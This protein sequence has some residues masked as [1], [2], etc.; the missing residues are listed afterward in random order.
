MFM[1]HIQK[2][3]GVK[4]GNVFSAA[5]NKLLTFITMKTNN[6]TIILLCIIFLLPCN[7]MQAQAKSKYK[8]IWSDEFN[9]TGRPDSSKWGYDIGGDGWGNQELEYYTNRLQNAKVKKGILKITLKK[10]TYN[11]SAYTSARLLSK[12]KFE[13]TYGKVEARAKLPVGKGT[14]PAIWMLGTN[15]DSVGWPHCGEIDIMEHIGRRQDTIYATF[16]YPGHSG[17]NAD[18]DTKPI[19]NAATQFHLYS[20][21]W[22]KDTIKIYV[23]HILIHSLANSEKLPFNHDFFLILN[24]AMGGGL[25]GDVDPKFKNA[26]MEV[27][28]VRVYQKQ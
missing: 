9:Y 20:L 10:E 28:Y 6:S 11:G 1:L 5:E 12:G 2:C 26:S 24:I 8:L 25:G 18:G 4:I 19:R 22:N 23:G 15:A 21:E 14:W 7:K 16:H 27:D 13:F 17:G 3:L